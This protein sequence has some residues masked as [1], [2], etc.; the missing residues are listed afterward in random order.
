MR[1]EAGL[2]AAFLLSLAV[3]AAATAVTYMSLRRLSAANWWVAHTQE[4]RTELT[5]TLSAFQDAETGQ[6]GYIITGDLTYLVPFR[7]AR[8]L[9][10]KRLARLEALT[11]DDPEQQRLIPELRRREVAKLAELRSTIGHR[12]R[13]GFDA[14]ERAVRAG[15]G[16][17]EMDH[18]RDLVGQMARNEDALS[19]ARRREADRASRAAWRSVGITVLLALASLGI[20]YDLAGRRLQYARRLAEERGR[21][22]EAQARLATLVESSEDAIIGGRLDGIITSWN[23]GAERIFGYAAEEMI[24]G[25]LSR[26]APPDRPDEVPTLLQAVQRG[27]RVQHFETERVRK[28][29]R[30]I[31]IS[32]GLSPIKDATGRIIGASSVARDVTERKNA[33]KEREALLQIAERARAEAE[34]ASRAKDAFLATI[35]HE[36]RTPLSPILAWSHM[37]RQGTLD[38]EKTARAVE[39]IERSARS[40][41]QLIE[42]LLDVSRIVAGKLRLDVRPVELAPVVQA[43]VDVVRPAAEA[44]SIQIQVVLDPDAGR[45]SGDPERLQ[46]VVWNLLSNA[47][48]FTPKG[49]HVQ[50]VLERVNSHVEIAVSDTGPGISPDFLPHVFERFQ[51]GEQG[52]SRAHSG[53]GLGLAIVRHIVELHGGT[54]HA[55]SPGIGQGTVFTL[56]LP[57]IVIARTAGEAERR[58]PLAGEDE[59]KDHGYPQLNGLR[60]L[61]VDDEPDSNE[62]VRTLLASCGAEVRVAASAEQAREVLGRWRT[63]LLVSDVGMP[64]EDGYDLIASLR[65]Q[66]GT[67]SQIPAVALTAYASREDK[68]RLLSAGFQ[69]HVPK[70]LDAAELVTVVASIARSASRL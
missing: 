35:S 46:Q 50:V 52:P 51:Q 30:R 6:R 23:A 47:I 28:D 48:K 27:E 9:L 14:A 13:A 38:A 55:E 17:Q 65:A 33:E 61:L 18:V 53:L 54:V 31:H 40:Q 29:G 4:V 24:G 67:Q 70:P 8:R 12:K 7:T 21:V 34:F 10:P 60:V 64:G 63:D 58:H 19:L 3:L 16:K 25:P 5:E 32:L 69:A 59:A 15:R 42:D 68:I 37:L 62:V 43:S 44:K 36:L 20:L 26:L 66:E 56:K 49:G 45:V 22:A 1:Q 41:A 11:K 2:R 57:L 39:T